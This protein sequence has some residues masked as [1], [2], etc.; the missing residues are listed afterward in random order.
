VNDNGNPY[1]STGQKPDWQIMTN[2]LDI[3]ATGSVNAPVAG[4]TNWLLNQLQVE[5]IDPN[6]PID[7]TFT[8]RGAGQQF[9]NVGF[10][11]DVWVSSG[12]TYTPFEA[13]GLTTGTTNAGGLIGNGGS[14][15]ILNASGNMDV[16]GGSNPG[17]TPGSFFQ[18]PGGLVLKAGSVLTTHDPIYNA[19]T[20]EAQSYQGVF[21]EA[22]VINNFGYIATNG[23]SWANWN[24]QPTTPVPLIYQITQPLPTTLAFHLAGDAAHKNTYSL[25]I[26]GTPVNTCP[27]SVCGW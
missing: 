21:F 23:N 15:M 7:F 13:V 10:T 14:Q 16:Y 17:G 2:R 11:G 25:L 24:V 27:V 18:F 19:W 20:T 1:T 12:D 26:T 4:N 6:L 5:A 8:A 9:W 3:D 22:P